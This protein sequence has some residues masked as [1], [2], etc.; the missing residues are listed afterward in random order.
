MKPVV[1]F[2]GVIGE[3]GDRHVIM[4]KAMPAYEVILDLMGGGQPA[5]DLDWGKGARYEA[6][7]KVATLLLDYIGVGNTGV[8]EQFTRD[9]V[10]SRMKREKGWLL[11]LDQLEEWLLVNAMMHI[12]DPDPTAGLGAIN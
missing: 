7:K 11:S 4:S 5:S 12:P 3:T 10:L 2:T 9:V 8:V 6:A 1:F